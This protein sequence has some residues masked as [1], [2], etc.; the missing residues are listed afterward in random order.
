MDNEKVLVP[1]KFNSFKDKRSEKS[2]VEQKE[3]KDKINMLLH[4]SAKSVRFEFML[5]AVIKYLPSL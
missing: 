1:R 5:M 2:V 4:N 3:Q